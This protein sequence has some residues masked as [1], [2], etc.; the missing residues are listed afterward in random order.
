[1]IDVV[2]VVV[3]ESR[4]SDKYLVAQRPERKGGEWEFPGGKVEHGETLFDALIREINEELGIAVKPIQTLGALSKEIHGQVY[5]IHFIEAEL[6][7]WDIRLSEH[8]DYRW[9]SL[10]DIRKLNISSVDREFLDQLGS[11]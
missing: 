7:S 10:S 4:K 3:K 9:L 5:R 2:A 1:M 11:R 8:Q 6:L